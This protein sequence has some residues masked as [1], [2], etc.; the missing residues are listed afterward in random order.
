LSNKLITRAFL[1]RH[2]DFEC[3]VRAHLAGR[4]LPA[5]LLEIHHRRP[6]RN[7]KRQMATDDH[8]RYHDQTPSFLP[9]QALYR[10][11]AAK[12]GGIAGTISPSDIIRAVLDSGAP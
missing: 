11:R 7:R 10:L 9:V 5:G 12:A 6:V 1:A 2:T 4:L 8:G 3:I